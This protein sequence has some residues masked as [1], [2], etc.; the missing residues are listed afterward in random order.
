[1]DENWSTIRALWDIVRV[2]FG[3]QL[4]SVAVSHVDTNMCHHLNVAAVFYSEPKILIK[5]H[6]YIFHVKEIKKFIIDN[7]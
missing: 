7:L 5:S 1:M 6:K 3:L 4:T 2:V